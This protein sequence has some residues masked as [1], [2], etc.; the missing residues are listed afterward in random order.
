MIKEISSCQMC[1]FCVVGYLRKTLLVY[2]KL[3][4]N[5]FIGEAKGALG[6]PPFPSRSNFFHFHAVLPNNRFFKTKFR[7]W[8]PRLENPGSATDILDIA[9]LNPSALN[10]S[11]LTEMS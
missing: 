8:R 1:H 5:I 10:S 6:T 9:G 4:R 3:G 11:S 7:G 2:K